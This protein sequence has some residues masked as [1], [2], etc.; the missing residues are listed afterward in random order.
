[1]KRDSLKN[2]SFPILALLCVNISIPAHTPKGVW[3]YAFDTRSGVP[4]W[5]LSG[6]CSTLSPSDSHYKLQLH[7]EGRIKALYEAPAT[8]TASLAG[9]VA[10]SAADL[11]LRLSSVEP[12]PEFILDAIGGFYVSRKDKLSLVFD[13][14]ARTL[15][16]IDRVSR[17][18]EEVIYYD[19]KSFWEGNHMKVVRTTTVSTRQIEFAPPETA[20]GKWTLHLEMVPAENKLSGTG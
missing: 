5:N 3:E 2:R 6:S 7:H 11:R 15:S 9:T 18:R 19:P 16:G 10:G 1:M 13:A 4:L 20:D 12:A 8:A 14:D 17:T